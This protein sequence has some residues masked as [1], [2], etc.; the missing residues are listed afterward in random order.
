M[1]STFYSP[2]KQLSLLNCRRG[3]MPRFQIFAAIEYPNRGIKPLLQFVSSRHGQN[4]FCGRGCMDTAE[5]TRTV[6]RF[7][8]FAGG[9]VEV[10]PDGRGPRGGG[11]VH[12][13]R[14]PVIVLSKNE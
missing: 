12:A 11:S 1:R 7:A 14:R 10:C 4:T 9:A 5:T 13:L 8:V 6:K 2:G 3:F